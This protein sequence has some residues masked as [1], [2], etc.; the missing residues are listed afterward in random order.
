MEAGRRVY[1][2]EEV[3]AAD[4]M[5]RA[6]QALRAQHLLSDEPGDIELIP[7]DQDLVVLADRDAVVEALL[8]LLQNAIRYAPEPRV[9]QMH[10]R[11]KGKLVGFGVEDNGPGIPLSE[12]L[13]IFEKF[14]RA[15]PL[16]SAPA[17]EGSG[18]G[19]S[20]VRVIARDQG[21]SVE[22]ATEIGKGS[23]FTIWLP[24]A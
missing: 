12:R 9:I 24:S 3:S 22:L 15:N 17:A 1:E 23:C 5:V 20:I 18:L 8:N 7:N 16:L 4:I 21:G 10:L 11:T 14:Y 6:E 19:L 2:I 13:R